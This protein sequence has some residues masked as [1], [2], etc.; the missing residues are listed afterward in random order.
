[1]AYN[2]GFSEL[3]R[4]FSNQ[5]WAVLF[6]L[7]IKKSEKAN[8]KRNGRSIPGSNTDAPEELVPVGIAGSIFSSEVQADYE[9][10]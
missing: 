7:V 1:M 2:S 9:K 4:E 10:M 6:V 5:A 8:R 3:C